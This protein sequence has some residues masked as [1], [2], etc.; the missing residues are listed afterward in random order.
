MIEVPGYRIL[1]PLGRGG[2]ASVYLAIQESVDREVA[3]KVM[4][5]TLLGDPQFGERFLREARIAAKLRHPHVVQVHD[6]GRFDEIHYMAMEYLPGG[7]VVTSG[8]GPRGLRYALRVTREIASALGYAHA[9][10]VVHRDIKPDNILLREDGAA[11]LTDFGIARANDNVRMTRTGS[12]MGTPSYMSPEQAQGFE[13]DGRADL[14]SLGIVFFEL[15]VGRLPFAAQDSISVGVMHITAPV[16]QLPPELNWLQPLLNRLLAKEPAAR[17]QSGSDLAQALADIES[18]FTPSP[19]SVPS[20]HNSQ[21]TTKVFEP[22]ADAADT[23]PTLGQIDPDLLAAAAARRSGSRRTRRQTGGPRLWLWGALLLVGGGG[24]ALWTFQDQLREALLPRTKVDLDL[25][26]AEQAFREGRLAQLDGTEPGAA[27]LYEQVLAMD[28]ENQRAL[29][30]RQRLGTQWM[31]RARNAIAAQQFAEAEQALNQAKRY[32]PAAQTDA[33]QAQ[34]QTISVSEQEIGQLLAAADA[35]LRSGRIDQGADSALALYAQVLKLAPEN[36]LAKA[37][38]GD[39]LIQ[40]FE[41][42][43]TLSEQ[44]ELEAAERV[45]DRIAEV[46]PANLKLPDAR[47]RIAE[48]RQAGSVALSKELER[49]EQLLRQGRLSGALA[50]YRS[51]LEKDPNNSSAKAG[52]QSIV[53]QLQSQIDRVLGDF[54]IDRADAL[55]ATMADAGASGGQIAATRARISEAAERAAQLN[56]RMSAD[57][58]PARLNQMLQQAEQAMS[59]GQLFAPPGESAFDLFSRVLSADPSNALARA[60][61]D[62]LAGEAK[63]RFEES[64][65]GS[66]LSSARGYVEGLESYRADDPGLPGM[67]RRLASLY[68]GDARQRLERNELQQAQRSLNYARELDPNNPDS[69]ELQ[70]RLDRA[71]G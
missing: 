39:A 5:P 42:A 59:N 52:V 69:V 48:Q 47:A 1:K 21:S 62:R 61:R 43:A 67:K 54:Q 34:L 38:Q 6:V 46:E 28:P 32:V 66:R 16:P 65:A 11:V 49:A 53:S 57:R 8:A 7:S 37:G 33:L 50:L 12:I 9:R 56:S 13:I 63:R 29:Q 58:D 22:D 2:M 31:A 15:L 30:G 68:L 71:G 35:A 24:A 4:A 23:E 44:G 41:R 26:K 55:L 64:L 20:G 36:A 51:V 45:L 70:A 40:L 27:E 10:G 18:R 19:V 14:Y 17:F 25:E 60:G 3:L